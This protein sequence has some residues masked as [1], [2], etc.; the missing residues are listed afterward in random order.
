M[1][2]NSS[3]FE[4]EFW[5]KRAKKYNELKWTN[6]KKY[7][8]AF[9]KAG[10]FQKNDVVLDVGTGTG[11]IAH[12]ISPLVREVIGL[13]KSQDMLEHSNWNGNKYFIKRDILGSIFRDETFDKIT[14]RQ[15]FHHIIYNTQKAMDECYRLL[16]GSGKMILS[17]GIP[18]NEKVKGDY[19]RI[20]E[21]KEKRLTFLEKDLEDLMKKSGFKNIKTKT[22]ILEN[23]SVRNWLEK[24]GLPKE[25]QNRIFNLHTN[26]TDYFKRVYNLKRTKD[27]CLIDFKMAILVGEK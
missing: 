9:I 20:F 12:A 10:D 6:N 22:V 11:I 14:A 17:D 16:K 15:V 7:L 4:S 27:D 13:D 26:S 21:L 5:R 18:P 1:A 25:I 8:E 23:M 19:I 24:S 2:E 3:N